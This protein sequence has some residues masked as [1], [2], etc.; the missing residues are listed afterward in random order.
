[1][2]PLVAVLA[3]LSLVRHRQYNDYDDD[4]RHHSSPGRPQVRTT[5]ALHKSPPLHMLRNTPISCNTMDLTPFIERLRELLPEDW[6]VTWSEPSGP[7]DRGAG[8]VLRIRT[9]D[10]PE[11]V[12]A[13][14]VKAR[15]SA[16]VA[17][18]VAS[19]LAA[20]K[21]GNPM[22]FTRYLS[23]MARI[24]LR[25]AG[26]S[27]LDLTG[28]T[29]VKL[30]SP[31][32]LI[33]RQ[34]ADRDPDPPKRGLR[35]LKGPKAG[36][37]VRALC[38]TRPP[39]G[40]RELARR[41]GTDPSYAMRVLSLLEAEDIV[42]RNEGGEVIEVRWTELLRR[43]SM[44]YSV[45]ETNRA[46]RYLAPR[47]LADLMERLAAY[48]RRPYA[49]TGAAAVPPPAKV[50][51]DRILSL[52]APGIETA[53]EALDLRPTDAGANAILLEPVD[54]FVFTGA[55]DVAGLRVVAPS[56]CA[57][58]LLTGSGREPSQAEALL[59]WM[60]ENEDAWRSLPT[61]RRWTVIPTCSGPWT[62]R[63]GGRS[64][65]TSRGRLLCWSPR[66]S[67]SASAP[68]VPRAEATRTRWTCSGSSVPCR[69][70]GSAVAWSDCSRTPSAR[71]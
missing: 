24:R 26:I 34:G 62:R 47:G 28:N 49:I 70:R 68:T 60:R 43:W 17:A 48:G 7:P 58:D 64:P 67:R 4:Q 69:Q 57:A 41:T 40:V 20:S 11:A 54:E 25:G 30:A 27:Y 39:V 50:L 1:V 38:D 29:W 33:D 56:Q 55:R 53:A 66:S 44:D 23:P 36:R 63:M 59:N 15:L 31:Y 6:Q 45:T 12:L 42:G 32:V 61:L 21:S 8:T 46:V 51:P 14:E 65:S 16:Q 71:M 5:R 2:L 35:S 19:T 9:P 10:G 3:A 52:Y 22:V 37:I 18:S 13:V